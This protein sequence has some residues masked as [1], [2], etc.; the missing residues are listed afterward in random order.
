[1]KRFTGSPKAKRNL[2]LALFSCLAL[3]L[4]TSCELIAGRPDAIFP[5][6]LTITPSATWTPT[7]HVTLTS[8]PGSI[9][10]LYQTQTAAPSIF[11]SVRWPTATR[12]TPTPKYTLTALIIEKT[13]ESCLLAYPDF[14][15]SPDKRPGCTE[16]FYLGKDNF[17]VLTPDPYGY[18]KDRDGIGCNTAE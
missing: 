4:F 15:I 3:A 14:C 1:M 13:A 7:I 18:D 11:P 10:D 16:L 12:T 5:Y 6:T 17:T 2:L 8:L 9:S